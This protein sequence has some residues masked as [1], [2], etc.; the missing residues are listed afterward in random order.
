[1]IQVKIQLKPKQENSINCYFL[2]IW[3]KIVSE[4]A[5]L[6]QCDFHHILQ[7]Y[8]CAFVTY[9]WG[10]LCINCCCQIQKHTC[11]GYL[12]SVGNL[13]Q[14]IWIS[15]ISVDLDPHSHVASPSGNVEDCGP[16]NSRS[17]LWLWIFVKS[18][19]TLV[20]SKICFS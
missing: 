17:V 2:C 18:Y 9:A 4:D 8:S 12:S 6:R 20:T 14:M 1:M 11:S 16:A 3:I 13:G 19:N 10:H 5:R 15:G 7:L